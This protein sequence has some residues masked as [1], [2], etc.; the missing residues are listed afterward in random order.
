M[1]YRIPG[2]ADG[3]DIIYQAQA[4]AK[5]IDDKFTFLVNSKAYT[6]AE[7]ACR[8]EG[9]KADHVLAMYAINQSGQLFPE[10]GFDTE[11][12]LEGAGGYL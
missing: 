4:D 5:V 6:F 11:L 9:T 7:G 3:S 8:V 1:G 12:L 2:N 10:A